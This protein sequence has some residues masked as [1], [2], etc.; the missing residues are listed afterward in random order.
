MTLNFVRL[1]PA[2]VT[3]AIETSENLTTWTTVATMAAGEEVWTGSA[4][5]QETG[6]GGTRSVIVTPPVPLSAHQFG[7]LR[8]IVP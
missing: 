4:T 1:A 6:S 5:V 8:A 7:R 2:A 3:Y